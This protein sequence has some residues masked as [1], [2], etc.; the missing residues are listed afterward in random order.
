M[1]S[2]SKYDPTLLKDQLFVLEF[3]FFQTLLLLKSPLSF[4]WY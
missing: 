4:V 1:H 3:Q 2:V